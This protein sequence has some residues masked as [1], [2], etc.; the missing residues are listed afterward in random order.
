MSCG[1]ISCLHHIFVGTIHEEYF[2]YNVSHLKDGV[3]SEERLLEAE[4]HIFKLKP[5]P[6]KSV[7]GHL[8]HHLQVI[9][10]EILSTF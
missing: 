5:R 6:S 9:I 7:E 4:F 10:L 3:V 8:P 1:P 2:F